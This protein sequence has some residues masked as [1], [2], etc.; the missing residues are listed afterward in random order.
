MLSAISETVS[1]IGL[2][3]VSAIAEM[4]AKVNVM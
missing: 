2:K 1:A 4:R 3:Q